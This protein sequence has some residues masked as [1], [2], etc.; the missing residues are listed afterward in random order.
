[1]SHEYQGMRWLKCDL[2]VQTPEDSAH[3]ADDD[4]RLGEPRRPKVDGVHCENSIQ[5]KAR[6][7]LTRCHELKLDVIGITDHNFSQKT[8]PRDWFLTHLVEQNKRVAREVGRNPLVIFP[9]FEVSIGYHVL[10]L[11]PPAKKQKQ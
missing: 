10:C 1:M 8:D 11:F 7:F 2:Q 6:I 3:W 9:G 4:L 5:E